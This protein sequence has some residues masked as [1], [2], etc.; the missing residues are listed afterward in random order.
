VGYVVCDRFYDSTTAYQGYGRGFH[1]EDMRR[2]N[3]F[4]VAGCHPNL[5]LLLSLTPEEGF[6]RLALRGE[7]L[8]RMEREERVFH[9]RVYEGY[10]KMAAA[11]SERFSVVDASQDPDQVEEA[12][13]RII[14][15]RLKI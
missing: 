15:D 7:E 8:D 12:I 10:L 5:T 4:A 2:I 14:R 6:K 11:E 13:L 9:Q 3:N 1:I